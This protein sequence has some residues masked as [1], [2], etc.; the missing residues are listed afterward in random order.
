MLAIAGY[1]CWLT[2]LADAAGLC[3]WLMLLADMYED[4]VGV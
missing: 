4:E 1:S 3:C 2:L